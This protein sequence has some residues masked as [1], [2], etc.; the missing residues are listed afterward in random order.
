MVSYRTGPVLFPAIDA[1]LAPDQEGVAELILV[2]NGNPPAVS[3]ALAR[4]A[5]AEPRLRLINGH[6]NI[7]YAGGCN[8]GAR[9]ARGR[10]LLLLNPDCCLSSGA[11]PSLLAETAALGDDWMLGWR[12]RN[13][14]GTDQRGSRRVLLTPLTA[15]VEAIRL[16]R[17]SPTLFRRHRLNRHEAALP[18]GTG[19]VPAVSGA[20]MMP[21]A[22][23]YRAAG[24]MDEGYFLHVEDLDFC[25][26]LHRAGVPTYFVP[27]VEA[28]HHGSTSRAYPLLIEWHKTHG[29]LR[30]FGLHY[31]RLRLLPALAPLAVAILG[32]LG[33]RVMQSLCRPAG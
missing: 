9:G 20:C 1:V 23:T 13:P 2:D 7:G 25:L 29:F 6:G 10:H 33:L 31:G 21:P 15:L 8:L 30:Y 32:R 24:G 17:V 19:R 27:H 3:A 22:A 11:V 4:R 12:V 28:V 16:D 14:D 26:R 5:A 18:E